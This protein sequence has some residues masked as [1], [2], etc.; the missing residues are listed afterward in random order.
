MSIFAYWVHTPHPFLVQF[1]QNIGIRYY[2][3]AYLLGFVIGGWL[4]RIYHRSGRTPLTPAQSLDFLLALTLGVILGGR[5]GYFILYRPEIFWQDPLALVRVWEGGMSS[6]GGFIG[7][8]IATVVF[9]RRNRV[10]FFH[11]ADLAV[12]AAPAGL[13]LGRM[14]NFLNGELWGREATVPWAMIFSASGGG[15]NPRHPSQ[16]YEAALE[17]L[18][19]FGLV[20][21]RLWKTDVA[22]KSPG[23]LAGEF[24][25]AYA[26][27]RAICELFRE[28]DADLIG[29][30]SRGTYYSVFLLGG[31]AVLCLLAA[32]LQR[33]S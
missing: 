25:I 3:V 9:A 13:F 33:K 2:G 32:R 4:F 30:V 14:A 12:S 5:L 10:S 31:G 26:V 23:R 11:L 24:L 20:Q 8:C 17:G 18:F 7:V 19:L 28:P 22:V 16:L 6:H 27:V 29:G 21:F 1:T 15:E